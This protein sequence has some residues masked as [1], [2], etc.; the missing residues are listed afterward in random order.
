MLSPWER[1]KKTKFL[2]P[3]LQSV[4]FRGRK[5]WRTSSPPGKSTL[6]PTAGRAHLWLQVDKCLQRVL[7]AAGPGGGGSPKTALA[8]VGADL[9]PCRAHSS[10]VQLPGGARSNRVA[11]L[12]FLASPGRGEPA[13][14]FR[15]DFASSPHAR[16]LLSAAWVSAP[17]EPGLRSTRQ[18]PEAEAGGENT[19]GPNGGLIP[20][21]FHI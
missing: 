7:R 15:K 4:T 10:A 17:R 2:L 5:G 9:P 8:S 13:G 21:P 3:N 14:S 12:F 16:P 18:P 11:G 19:R 6:E 20:A 1:R